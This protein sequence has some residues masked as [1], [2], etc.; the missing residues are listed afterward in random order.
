[1]TAS[2]NGPVWFS[3]DDLTTR[4]DVS[5]VCIY[6]WQ[7]KRGF[8]KAVKLGQRMVRWPRRRCLCVGERARCVKH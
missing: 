8:P 2:G 1:M 6:Q 7:K 5:R 4:Y 3:M